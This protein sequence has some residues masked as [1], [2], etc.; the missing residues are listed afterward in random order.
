M[1]IFIQIIHFVFYD[2]TMRL[3]VSLIILNPIKYNLKIQTEGISQS[4][5]D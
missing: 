1:M 3:E 2:F 4:E 5:N